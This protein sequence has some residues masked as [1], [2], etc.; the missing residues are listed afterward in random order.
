M[1]DKIKRKV[2]H[3]YLL[4]RLEIIKFLAREI[5]CQGKDADIEGVS[6]DSFALNRNT[7]FC[8]ANVLTESFSH[9][10]MFR[11]KAS[12]ILKVKVQKVPSSPFMN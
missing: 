7:V 5:G 1:P 6:G 12:I 8:F 4:R 2:N 3:D 10:P 11:L 9:H